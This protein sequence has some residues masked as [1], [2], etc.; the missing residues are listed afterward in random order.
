MRRTAAAFA[1]F[2]FAV[3]SSAASLVAS[4]RPVAFARTVEWGMLVVAHLD[5]YN[6]SGT[7][8]PC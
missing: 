3:A 5:T 8:R 7:D 2:A 6:Q 1:A 4:A